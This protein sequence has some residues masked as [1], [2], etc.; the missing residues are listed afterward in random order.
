MRSRTND[1]WLSALRAPGDEQAAAVA[2]LRAY[3]VRAALYVLRRRRS[4]LAHL[5]PTDIEGLAEDCAQDALIAVLGRLDEFRGESRFTTWV[6]KFAINIALVAVRREGGKRVPLDEVLGNADAADR[7]GAAEGPD[8][9]RAARRTE[10]W[11]AIQEAMRRELTER[12][13]QALTAIVFDGIPLDELVRH[14]GSNRNAVYKV[15]HDARRK[16]KASLERR[17][18][19]VH[20]MLSLFSG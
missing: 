18:L 2:D 1:E 14:W 12:Q 8:P 5:S 9:D 15:L 13:R 10:A 16:L 6:Y 19:P 17:D 11:G 4:S 20:E 3:L 7:V